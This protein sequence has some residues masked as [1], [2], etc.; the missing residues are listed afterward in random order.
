MLVSVAG[1]GETVTLR[2]RRAG[3]CQRK[4]S[5]SEVSILR[6]Y[7]LSPNTRDR[8][9]WFLTGQFQGSLAPRMVAPGFKVRVLR[10]RKL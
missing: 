1:L 5:A 9:T 4:T 2:E 3:E 6:Y 10:E 7:F 8:P